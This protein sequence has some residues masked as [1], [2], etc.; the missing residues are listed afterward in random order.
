MDNKKI[1]KTANDFSY[2][3]EQKAIENREECFTIL[4]E[5]CE[6]NDV[7]YEKIGDMVNT[8][9]REKLRLE[10]ADMGMLSKPSSLFDE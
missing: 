1:F 7:E 6:N 2:F 4:L 3:I 8:Q 5:F 9:L 10:F